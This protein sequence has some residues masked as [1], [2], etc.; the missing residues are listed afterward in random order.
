MYAAAFQFDLFTLAPGECIGNY[1]TQKLFLATLPI[2]AMAALLILGIAYTAVRDFVKLP[3]KQSSARKLNKTGTIRSNIIQAANTEAKATWSLKRSVRA[4]LALGTPPAIIVAF[5]LLPSISSG[6]FEV[7]DCGTQPTR[8]SEVPAFPRWAPLRC[9]HRLAT[10]VV[11][12]LI[13]PPLR[14]P[15]SRCVRIAE[16]FILDDFTG[17]SHYY[18][19]SSLTIRCSVDGY[20]NPIYNQARL[21][22]SIFVAIW[23]VGFPLATIGLMLLSRDALIAKRASF[24]TRS[25]AFLHREYR[26]DCY[27]WEVVEM[28]RRLALTGFV[29]LV[30]SP[31]TE[32][33]RLLFAQVVTFVSMNA[34]IFIRPYKRADNN[35]LAIISQMVLLFVL[36]LA[37]FI[38]LYKDIADTSLDAAGANSVMG[39]SDPFSFSLV[40]FSINVIMLLITLTYMLLQA[41]SFIRQRRRQIQDA[42]GGLTRFKYPFNVV[43]LKKFQQ[44][45]H[46]LTHEQMRDAGALTVFDT[47]DDALAFSKKKVVVFFSHQWLGWTQPDPNNVHFPVMIQAIEKLQDRFGHHA[48][49]M[50][51]WIGKCSSS[52]CSF[53]ML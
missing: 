31:E 7:F 13:D 15:S 53:L 14:C 47:W 46:L 12:S 8:N 22:A 18:L 32:S 34:I 1:P 25:F 27:W 39:S 37:L 42:I 38:K 44:G 28:L 10:T 30:L 3:K 16:R 2:A 26:E 20:T 9:E 49:D 35:T 52:C 6:L 21:I 11:L 23:P 45:G 36:I 5:C 4:G 24:W 48:D 50:Y 19:S 17:E 40:L 33:L 29:V 43:S 41:R 51:I